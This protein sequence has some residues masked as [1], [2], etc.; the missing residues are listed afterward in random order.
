MAFTVSQ[1]VNSGL[2]N[3]RFIILRVTAD[4]ATGTVVPGPTLIDDASYTI[5]AMASA[6]TM[7]MPVIK[8]NAGVSGTSIAGTIAMTNCVS[9]DIYHLFVTSRA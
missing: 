7:N 8:I 9:S 1:I 3:K 4:A 6:P 5:E 2:E